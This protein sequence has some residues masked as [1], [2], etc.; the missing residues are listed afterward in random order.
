MVDGGWWMGGACMHGRLGGW[1]VGSGKCQSFLHVEG[2]SVS[3]N[4]SQL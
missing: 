2:S 3:Q 1:E 4:N